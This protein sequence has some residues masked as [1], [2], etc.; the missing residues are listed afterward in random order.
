MELSINVPFFP[1]FYE[2]SLMNSDTSYWA[3]KE[4]LDYIKD[5]L[6]D[7]HPEYKNLTEDDLDF[8]YS[9]YETDVAHAFLDAWFNHAPSIVEDVEYEGIDSPKYY[10][11]RNDEL[12]ATIT[13]K[14]G[15]EDVMRRFMQ[16]N[17]E[18]LTERIKDDWTSYDGFMSF[19]ENDIKEWGKYLFEDHDERYIA[20]MLAYMMYN[21]N[22]EIRDTLVMDALEDIYTDSYVFITDE[23][24]E[25][26][27]EDIKEGRI[28]IPDPAQLTIPFED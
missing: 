4:E 6:S 27:A 8:R 22:K 20:T 18:W 28:V 14:E 12:Y 24:K 10:N 5:E 9:D 26:L 1:G 21:E 7:D 17:A 13:L 19:M 16:E 15:W 3:I 11:F 23:A 25:R 2:S